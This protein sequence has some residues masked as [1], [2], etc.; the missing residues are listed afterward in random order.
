MEQ[1]LARWAH[2]PKVGGSNP[3]PRYFL[4]G[5]IAQLVE[6]RNHN[7]W[8]AG[9][10]PAAATLCRC[11]LGPYL[12]GSSSLPDIQLRNFYALY[13]SNS[14]QSKLF[15]RARMPKNDRGN[16]VLLLS[17]LANLICRSFAALSLPYASRLVAPCTPN[18]PVS[19][20]PS[21]NFYAFIIYWN[22]A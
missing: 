17:S 5:G 8:V 7:P 16:L 21:Y 20:V 1:G 12:S 6:Q 9:S 15:S 19:W 11:P 13:H 4:L 2:N 18:F 22:Y 3:L 10:S 14:Q